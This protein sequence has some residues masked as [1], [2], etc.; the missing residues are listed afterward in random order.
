MN[1]RVVVFVFKERG[2]FLFEK[3]WDDEDN[4]AG[5]WAFPMG[6][7][8]KKES[9]ESALRREIKEELGIKFHPEDDKFLCKF[10]QI[11]PT[12]KKEYQFNVYI[13]SDHRKIKTT[14]E[15]EKIAWFTLTQAEKKTL[16]RPARKIIN[17]LKK[18]KR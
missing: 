5:L 12:S 1:N 7:I 4:Y 9:I 8:R 14:Y 18:V 15:E 2:R 11:D 13:C 6:H 3:R 17:M 10:K 16:S